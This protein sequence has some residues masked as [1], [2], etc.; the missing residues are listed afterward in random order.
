[1]QTEEEEEPR[2]IVS[3]INGTTNTDGITIISKDAGFE[4]LRIKQG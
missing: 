1:M 4:G 3:G 2:T